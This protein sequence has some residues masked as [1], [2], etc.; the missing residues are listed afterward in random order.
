MKSPSFSGTQA[1]ASASPSSLAEARAWLDMPVPANSQVSASILLNSLEPL[2]L[3]M[4]GQKLDS[5]S[6]TYY[7]A[8]ITRG[9]QVK[10]LRVVDGV[11]TELGSIKSDDYV[12]NQWVKLTLI[13]IDNRIEAIVYRS[14]T[15][16]YLDSAGNWSNT[17]T[18]A[19]DL[20]DAGISGGGHVG[21]V[22]PQQYA[23]TVAL[24]DFEAGPASGDTSAPAIAILSPANGATLTGGVTIHA[25]ASDANGVEHVEFLIDGTLRY[26]T[27]K[28][29]YDWTFDTAGLANGT[30]TIT[31]KA[32]D[33]GG[34]F[35]TASIS[36][37]A[38]NSIPDKPDVPRHYSHIRIASLAYSGTPIDSF[39]NNCC[40]T[41]S[42]W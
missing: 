7:A 18:R 41:A 24:D 36:I 23:G 16:R 28:T 2:Q 37:T 14:D 8:S 40:K 42:I 9:L 6:P 31:V 13:A 20:S 10:L 34:N 27:T 29:P 22:R 25:D 38:A 17:L 39:A 5:N 1:F 30:H 3:I 19:L 11:A 35:G 33:L 4:R 15:G 21:V 32:F 26:A 12:S